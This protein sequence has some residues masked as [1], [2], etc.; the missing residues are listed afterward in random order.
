MENVTITNISKI[1]LCIVG[2]IIGAGFASGQE[3]MSFF[4][5]YGI[6]GAWGMIVCGVL[7]FVY[8]YV[9]LKKIKVYNI[10]IIY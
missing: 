9:V 1:F 3:I 2:T 7:F 10:L 8:I 4:V 5:K 6:N